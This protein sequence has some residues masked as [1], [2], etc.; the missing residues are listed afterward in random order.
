[1]RQVRNVIAVS[2]AL[3]ATLGVSPVLAASPAATPQWRVGYDDKLC[4]LWRSYGQGRSAVTLAIK[5]SLTGDA[6]RLYIM[7]FGGTLAGRL[8]DS[9][10]L[11]DGKEIPLQIIDQPATE[12]GRRVTI[13]YVPSAQLAPALG[14]GR[15]AF[16]SQW[17]NAFDFQVDGL[18]D[19]IATLDS[20]VDGLVKLWKID[21][22]SQSKL[23]QPAK[24]NLAQY[25]SNDD[26]P[27]LA[28]FHGRSGITS[29][30]LVVGSDGRIW[31]CAISDS[32]GDA[33]LDHTSCTKL[34]ERARFTP[35]RDKSGQPAVSIL[36]SQIRWVMGSRPRRK[37][38]NPR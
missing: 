25:L 21:P 9:R 28:A 6:T 29:M 22:D 31:D 17:M 5:P 34:K 1:M 36:T 2:L 32:S 16:R 33:L 23:D 27:R 7:Y 8:S 20:C 19:A 30:R 38:I 12:K 11:Y 3:S 26:Y 13:A 10:L 4:M 18:Q 37:P 24:A 14:A 35:A 15:W